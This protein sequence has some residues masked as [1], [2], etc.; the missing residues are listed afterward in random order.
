MG[1]K[2]ENKNVH[3]NPAEC[4]FELTLMSQPTG[5][6]ESTAVIV[7][8]GQFHREA[9]RLL[10]G[11]VDVAAKQEFA[12]RLRASCVQPSSSLAGSFELVCENFAWLCFRDSQWELVT[13][14]HVIITAHP[15]EW[16]Y[17]VRPIFNI[18]VR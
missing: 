14:D 16:I 13:A 1:G 8:A 5:T 2:W 3:L 4:S 17:V 15:S 10:I 9:V 12:N 11:Y 7:T 18:K 6:G